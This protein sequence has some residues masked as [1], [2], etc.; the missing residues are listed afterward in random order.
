M[1]QIVE[2][3]GLAPGSYHAGGKVTELTA[4]ELREYID[5]TN[6][7]LAA[8]W[9]PPVLYEHADPKTDEG[10]PRD[11]RAENVK[12]GAGWLK[13]IRGGDGGS[14]IYQL[15]VTDEE[16]AKKLKDG[17]IKFTSPETRKQW[18]DGTGRIFKKI[19]SHVALVHKP[20]NKDQGPIEFVEGV[21]QFSLEDVVEPMPKVVKAPKPKTA[22]KTPRRVKVTQYSAEDETA[23]VED[24]E[25][26]DDTETP[27][28]EAKETPENPDMPKDGDG[29][30]DRAQQIEAIL[31]HLEKLNVSLPADT[32][33]A[34]DDKFRDRLLTALKTACA[35]AEKAEAD[36]AADKAKEVPVPDPSAEPETPQIA[37]EKGQAIQQYSLAEVEEPKF[38]NRLLAKVI[39]GKHKDLI[40]KIDRM[41]DGDS[42]LS[43][44]AKEKLLSIDGALQF[45][46]EGEYVGAM[47]IEEVVDFLD[48]VLPP[49]L[50]L[51]IDQ[52]SVENHPS[53]EFIEG[54]G[55]EQV[56]TN[57]AKI[58]QLV[59]ESIANRRHLYKT[60]KT[61]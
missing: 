21:N 24:T 42:K 59:E 6:E 33:M 32:N 58:D 10:T 7:M 29:E 45:S 5:G 46:T 14:L 28:G 54:E 52:F 36:A 43:A 31:A 4:A 20:R 37:E 56:I 48:E 47:T 12:H 39:K 49:G 55:K 3:V 9:N 25:A 22:K 17:S 51:Q 26:G 41:I 34:D 1:A 38:E 53:K 15:E 60:K 16:A 18:T 2:Q 50:A 44:H 11:K 27:A 61:A 8:G 13:G 57:P 30:G 35:M 23:V 19:I 40:A